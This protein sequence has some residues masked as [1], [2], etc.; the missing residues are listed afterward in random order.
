MD[1]NVG[2][3]Q[4]IPMGGATQNAT[5]ENRAKQP[6]PAGLGSPRVQQT[7]STSTMQMNLEPA[8][9]EESVP[10][11]QG[12][13]WKW[14][15]GSGSVQRLR[16]QGTYSWTTTLCRTERLGNSGQVT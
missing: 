3:L 15:S 6:R 4:T 14:E 7:L 8:H 5:G 10:W 13:H 9:L 12:G 11:G 2:A 1:N 16:G